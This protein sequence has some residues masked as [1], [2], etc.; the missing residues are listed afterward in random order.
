MARFERILVATDFEDG[1]RAALDV[2]LDLG[3]RLDAQLT[4]LHV[5]TPPASTY[6]FY[7]E[8]LSWPIEELT[9][10]AQKVMDE[11]VMRA[12]ASHSSIEGM[13]MGGIA[14]ESIVAFAESGRFDLIVMGTHGR[15]GLSRVLLGRVAEK[16]VRHSPTPVLTVPCHAPG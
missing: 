16:V 6:A 15:R 14:S 4:L 10:Q 3:Q 11:V 9:A 8:G 7:A 1:A 13:V 12:R 2:A 5:F